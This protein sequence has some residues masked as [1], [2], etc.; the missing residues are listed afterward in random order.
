MKIFTGLPAF[1]FAV[2]I[3]LFAASNPES[4]ALRIWPV[5]YELEAPAFLA[6]LAGAAFGL[7]WGGYAAWRAG[8]GVRRRMRLAE[9]EAAAARRDVRR[10]ETALERSAAA[11]GAGDAGGAPVQAVLPAGRS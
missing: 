3:I 8:A 9:A 6:P 4:V 1:L 7:I 2:L 5:P 11:A 10:L